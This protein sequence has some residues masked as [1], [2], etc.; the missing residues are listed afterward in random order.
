MK[1]L[2]L[3]SGWYGCMIAL[4]CK[5]NNIEYIILDKDYIF[6]GSSSKNQNRL[7]LGYHYP[8]SPETIKECIEGYHLF[9]YLFDKYTKDIKY[10]IYGIEKNSKVDYKKYKNIFSIKKDKI[11]S[12]QI[13]KNI[14]LEIN[15][16]IVEKT[17]MCDEKRIN[18][19][20]IKK[21]FI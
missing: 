9:N 6:N 1:V 5:S 2:I 11:I 19:K 21:K 20:K 4:I 13:L 17:F 14:E 16:N 7:H 15:K 8:R 10:N 12:E 18:H 3:G